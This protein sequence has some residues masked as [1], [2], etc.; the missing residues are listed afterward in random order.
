MRR[1]SLDSLAQDSFDVAVIGG[2]VNGA[3][4]AQELAS[5]G[6]R[7]LIIDKGDFTQGATGR[8]SRILHCGLRHLT[9]GTSAWEFAR[10]PSRFLV[11]CRNARKS[12]LSQHQVATTMGELVRPFKFCFPIYSDGP[13]AS[14]QVDAGFQ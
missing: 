7:V 8:S 12:M 4:A 11:A 6:Y 9:P 3:G 2:G 13:Y 1:P 14:W 10:H 5:R